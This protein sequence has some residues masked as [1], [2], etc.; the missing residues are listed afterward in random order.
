MDTSFGYLPSEA[1]DVV[2][3]VEVKRVLDQE[4]VFVIDVFNREKLSL[5]YQNKKPPAKWKEYPS[6]FLLQK[7]TISPEGG[8]LWDLWT[9]QNKESGRL[10][11][12]EH[13]VR[14]YERNKLES[15]LEKAG[16]V[17]KDVYGGYKEENFSPNS[18]RLILIAE[19]K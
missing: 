13:A 2:S 17:V 14:L 4:G 7:R 9:I 11:I 18:S 1:D 10:S 19:A 3:L 8:M 16:F 6:F 5:K 12:F 15:M